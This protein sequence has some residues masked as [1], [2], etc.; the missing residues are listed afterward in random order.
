VSWSSTPDGGYEVTTSDPVATAPAVVR[1]LVGVG[2]DVVSVAESHHSL[3]DVYLQLV[4]EDSE[5]STK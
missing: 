5:A 1:A 3:E 4:G 2:A